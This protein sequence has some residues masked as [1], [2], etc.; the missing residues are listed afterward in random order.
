MG[1][2]S[3]KQKIQVFVFNGLFQKKKLTPPVEDI[4]FLK[5][6]P[7]GNPHFSSIFGVPPGIPTTSTLPH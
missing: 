4:D 5:V 1:L 2:K 6:D 7:P 3:E